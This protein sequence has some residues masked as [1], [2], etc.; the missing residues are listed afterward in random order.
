MFRRGLLIHRTL[1]GLK[2]LLFSSTRRQST[3][4]NRAPIRLLLL[5]TFLLLLLLPSAVFADSLRVDFESFSL[6][7]V[8][9]QNGWSKTGSYDVEIVSNTSAPPSFGSQSLRISNAVTSGAFGD[10][11]FSASLNDEAGEST[12]LNGGLSG[13]TRQPFFQASW[14]V[15]STV[16]GAEQAGLQVTASPDRGDGARMSWI[17]VADTPGGLDVNFYGYDTTLGGTCSDLI[18]FVYSSPVSGLDRTVPHNIK[19]TMEFLDGINNDVVKLY[20]DGILVETGKSWEDYFRNCE[21][22]ESRTVDSILFRV[23]GTPATATFGNGFLIDNFSSYSGPVSET[24]VVVDQSSAD[25][26]FVEETANG[27]GSFVSGPGTPPAGTGSA[28]LTVDA[29]GGELFGAALYGGTYL[30]DINALTYQTYRQ[31]GA[32]ALAA[33]LQLNVDYD[34]TD[35]NNGWQGRLVYEPYNSGTNPSTGLWEEWDALGADAKWWASGVPGNTLCPQSSPC[36]LGKVLTN[37]PNLGVHATIPGIG[38]KAG[39]NWASGFT[40]NVDAFTIQVNGDTVH[41]DFEPCSAVE[42]EDT[43][44]LFC[45]IQDAI[46]DSDTNSG[47]TIL[48][49][50]GVYDEHVVVDKSLTLKGAGAGTNPA[51]HTIL[52]GTGLAPG[53]GIQINSGVTNVMIEALTVQDYTLS[54]SNHAG[55]VGL[56]SNNNFTLRNAELYNNNGGR[57]GVYLNGPVD[58]VLID[59]VTAHNNQGR[60]IVIWNGFKTNITITNNDVQSTNCCGIEL[61]DGTA[62]GVTMSGNTVVSNGDSGMS[63]IGLTAGAGPNVISNN[64]VTNN[65]RFGIEI[66][67]PDG[68]GLD[69]GDGSI[70]VEGNT[71]SITPSAT[72]NVRDHAGIAIFRRS[73]IAG[74]PTGYVD[75]PTGVVVRNNTVSGYVQQN[76]GASTSE[77]FGIVIE[78]TNHTVTGNTL[79]NNE[80]GI[81][82]QGGN[83]PNANYVPNE[84]GDGDQA[85]GASPNYFGRGNAPLACANT[86]IGNSFSGNATDYRKNVAGSGSGYVT[87]LTTGEIFC[88]IQAAI[89]DSDTDNGDVLELSADTFA[90]EVHVTKSLTI[91]GDSKTTT[92]LN[93]T[94]N[95]GTAGDARAWWLVDSGVD[96]T[97]QR[98]TFDGTGYK[99]WQA[100]RNKGSGTIDDVAFTEIKFDESGPSYAGTAVAAFGTG[101][102]NI[103]NAMFSEIGRVGVLYFGTG[104]TG[105]TFSGNMYTGKGD[106]DFLDYALDISAGAV[107]TVDDN[108]I[109]DNRGVASSDGSAS[110]G[111]LVTTYFGPGTQ[112]TILDNTI[113]A[114]TTAVSVGINSSDASTAIVTGNTFTDN[115]YGVSMIGSGTTATI[116]DNAITNSSGVGAGVSVNDGATA[117]IGGAAVDEGNSISGFAT[118]VDVDGATASIVGNE[119]D[120]NEVGVLF[121]DGATSTAF[122]YNNIT[123]NTT[124]GAENQSANVIDATL[125]WWNDASG[126]GGDGPGSGDAILETV[127]A[128]EICPWLGAPYVAGSPTVVGTPVTNV[129]TGEGFCT[130]QAAIDDSDTNNG[131]VIEV[132]AGTFEE[133]V[134]VYKEVTIQGQG[135]GNTIIKSPP[136]LTLSFTSSAANYPIVFVDGVDNVVLQELTVDGAGR[137]NSNYRFTGVAFYNASG[138]VNNVTIQDVRNEPLDGSQHGNA[139]FAYTDNGGPDT[140]MV[141]GA[142][143]SGFQKTGMIMAGNGLTGNITNSTVTG[144][145]PLGLGLPA[146]NGIQYSAGATGSVTDNTISDISYEPATWAACGLLLIGPAADITVSDNTLNDNQI[147]AYLID[148]GGT[149]SDNSVTYTTANMGATPY[150]WGI[151]ADPGEGNERQIL[152]SPFDVEVEQPADAPDAPMLIT[153]TIDNNTLEGDGNGVGIE[154][155]AFGSET[156]DVTITSN[157]VENFDYAV[158][159]YEE[160]PGATLTATLLDN[161]LTNSGQVGTGVGVLEGVEA[162]IGGTGVGEGNAISGFATGVDVDG[163]TASIVGNKIDS[164]E[165][166]VLFEDGATS[167]AFSYNNITNNT[168]AGAENQSANVIDATL[169]WWNDASGPGGDGPGS[170]DAIL[171]TVSGFQ[172]CPWLIAPYVAGSPVVTPPT[173]TNLNTSELFCSIQSA[174]DDS[175]T[176]T[177]HVLEASAGTFTENV[178]VYKGVVLQGQGNGTDPLVDTIVTAPSGNIFNIT[179]SGNS[180]TERLTIQNLRVD[181]AANGI[182]TDSAISY[183]TFNGLVVD[184][185]SN[186]GVDIH[187]NAGVTDLVITD[188]TFSNNNTGMRVRGALTGLDVGQSHFDD[189]VRNGFISEADVATGNNFTDINITNSSFN[190]ND[191]KGIYVEKFDNALVDQIEVVD[192]GSNAIYANRGALDINLKYGAYSNITLSNS[193]VTNTTPQGRIAV[194]LKARDDNSY[195]TNP[196]TLDGLT[197]DNVTVTGSITGILLGSAGNATPSNAV[198]KNSTIEAARGISVFT[199]A[200]ALLD[201]NEITIT[202]DDPESY[203]AGY[204][205]GVTVGSSAATTLLKNTIV[206]T[207]SS[208]DSNG[209]LVTPDFVGRGN[210]VIGALTDITQSNDISGFIRGVRVYGDAQIQGNIGTIENNQIGILVDTGGVS[211]IRF[212]DIAN[213]STGVEFASGA[214][215]ND[216]SCNNL[217]ANSTDANNQTA[218]TIDATYNYWGGTSDTTGSFDTYPELPSPATQPDCE[219]TLATNIALFNATSEEDHIAVRWATISE[220][221]LEGF[222]LYRSTDPATPG[223]TPLNATLIPAQNGGLPQGADYEFADY[224]VLS[225][226][227]Y[228]YWLEV[229][230]S[231]GITTIGPVEGTLANPTAITLTGIDA[232]QGGSLLPALMGALG[233]VLAAGWL[234]RR[235]G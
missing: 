144:A 216:F 45:T 2:S 83:H 169:N 134:H 91:Q 115:E 130:I 108:T 207:T 154:A 181:A 46:D 38:F 107:V 47:D 29:A 172:V 5:S 11:L 48:I 99:V 126:P 98:M 113:S 201:N 158:A 33:A 213:N 92:I 103:T 18:N 101:N 196:A 60:G 65:G 80:I 3:S 228:Y 234:R 180:A 184:G 218:T 141:D 155:D 164:N 176:A 13:G 145:G 193:T 53:S 188:S 69:T 16:P 55:V 117:T 157:T 217:V 9:E 77:G 195:S 100:I 112:A 206:N 78:G 74:N 142:E 8:N 23:A 67:N 96:L 66:K 34:L 27:S 224:D 192:S 19:V 1:V 131:D 165:L 149:V 6:G 152:A 187:N 199:L 223:S 129:D 170:G 37:W 127:S 140:V 31:S 32:V 75:V 133:Q 24:T 63:A 125:N 71:V 76:P 70:V 135:A 44:E 89:D 12:A 220:E 212:N 173:V 208:V 136:S 183:I 128:F 189:N 94:K 110:A 153:T 15:A 160:Q 41:Y 35:G 54:S 132:S 118:G 20:V 137:G 221:T 81:Q 59:N 175:G 214:T 93:P 119:I 186:Y 105:S 198:V 168:T 148:L 161:M 203:P 111:I 25:W 167:T 85:D 163:A 233:L 61:Q 114:S 139:F 159:L 95:T 120:S 219:T 174:I 185:A 166:G 40:G 56:G 150:W 182:Y 52:D 82:E 222:N 225:G 10:Q 73:F 86:I 235:N 232:K 156:L 26:A 14:D 178:T 122:S 211:A 58:T 57:G 30:R 194:A 28:E 84:A 138:S 43:G 121:Q 204:E 50:A 191:E 202:I 109:S 200:G 209:V 151:V 231:D 124:A 229:V 4:G 230:D 79:N 7:N 226:T 88:T 205:A 87:N 21:P 106:G 171:E 210:A 177:G 97:L 179:A 22:P 146:Q 102:V 36:T 68:T 64:D 215:S 51:T 72:M 104:I 197:V 227:L 162:T 147:G 143:I 190:R 62:S 17:Q 42:N 39:R 49:S 116:R 90:E 123:N